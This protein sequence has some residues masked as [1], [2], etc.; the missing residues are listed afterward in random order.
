MNN[1]HT[2]GLVLHMFLVS[3]QGRIQRGG[4]VDSSPPYE[5]DFSIKLVLVNL[6]S[7]LISSFNPKCL[8][9]SPSFVP[10]LD[11]PLFPVTFFQPF[12]THQ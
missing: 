9:F 7:L 5:S 4:W 2:A 1:A 11:P 6:K 8:L 3:S 10:I 12:E